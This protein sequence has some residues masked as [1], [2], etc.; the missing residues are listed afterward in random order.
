VVDGA[1]HSWPRFLDYVLFTHVANYAEVILNNLGAHATLATD[2][3]S[4]VSGLAHVEDNDRQVVVHAQRDRRRIH[5]F[6]LP[7]E[8]LT[9]SDLVEEL[10]GLVEHRIG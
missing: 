8:H 10:G 1:F 4:D 7:L 5:H 9:V 3:A 6:E 2:D